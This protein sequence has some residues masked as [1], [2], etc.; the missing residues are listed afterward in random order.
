MP[1]SA[2]P[3]RDLPRPVKDCFGTV[4]SSLK[5][6]KECAGC[7]LLAECRSINWDSAESGDGP[8]AVRRSPGAGPR[9]HGLMLRPSG[10]LV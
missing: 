2:P 7:E 5:K 1:E 8:A 10:S 9:A 3:R 4:I 6:M